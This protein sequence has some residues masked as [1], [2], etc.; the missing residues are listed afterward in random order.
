MLKQIPELHPKQLLFPPYNLR[1]EHLSE[2]L[3]VSV[4]AIKAWKYGKRSPQ[5]AIKK[6]CWL[7]AEKLQHQ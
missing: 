2:L 4:S 1:E 5:I 6:L 3:G 7:V